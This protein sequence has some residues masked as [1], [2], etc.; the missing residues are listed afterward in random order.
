MVLAMFRV[1]VF[2]KIVWTLFNKKISSWGMEVTVLSFHV[3][4]GKVMQLKG[5]GTFGF[6]FIIDGFVERLVSYHS[7]VFFALYFQNFSLLSL[8]SKNIF[9]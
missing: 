9:R 1:C 7:P 4:C 8:G 2:F 3:K 5:S 6:C